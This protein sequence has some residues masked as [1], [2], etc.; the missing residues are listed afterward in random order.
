[1]IRRPA[2]IAPGLALVAALAAGTLPAAAFEVP[3]A[4]VQIA[5]AVAAAP[6]GRRAD[7]TVLGYSPDGKFVELR[8][9]TNDLV[10]LADEPGDER[11][12]VACYHRSLEPYMARG[13]ELRAQGVEDTLAARHAEIE[14]G[15]LEMPRQPAIVYTY[16]GPAAIFDTSTGKLDGGNWLWAIYT[17][18][19]TE[20]STGLP[21]TPQTGGGPWI[22]RPGTPTAHVM[23]VQPREPAP[24]AK[25]E[26]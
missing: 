9:G 12:H 14:A 16:G 20:E 24:K 25:D 26:G 22:M 4:A 3:S 8:A 10:C 19:A 1:M 21:T 7:A 17:P 13:R 23:I 6:E 5:G 11:F 18:Y 15:R 2:R